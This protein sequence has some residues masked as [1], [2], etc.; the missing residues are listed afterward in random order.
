M[1]RREVIAG[2]GSAGTLWVFRAKAQQSGRHWRIDQPGSLFLWARSH[3]QAQELEEV[4]GPDFG[5][6]VA[7]IRCLGHD[8]PFRRDYR[9]RLAS[10]TAKP[11]PARPRPLAD[12]KG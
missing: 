2:V 7:S 9:E 5:G 6:A 4:R 12:L 8:E 3:D 10:K 11:P 1:K